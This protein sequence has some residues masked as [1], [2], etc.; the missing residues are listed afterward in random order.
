M[1]CTGVFAKNIRAF[2]ESKRFIINQGGARSSKTYSILQLLLL[3]CQRATG[4]RVVSVVSETLP[5]LKRGAI[6]DFIA[7]LEEDGLYS[8]SM[9][10]K[11]D[12]SFSIRSLCGKYTSVIEF[13]GADSHDKVRGPQRDYLFINE[14][15]NLDYESFYQLS[16]RTSKTVFIDFNPV[17]EFWVHTDL[18]PSLEEKDFSF[19]KSTY[20]D[21]EYLSEHQAADIERRAARDDNFRLV[22]ALGEIG[23]LEGLI[24]KQFKIVDELPTTDKRRIGIDFG[25]TNDPTVITDVRQFN[26]EWFVDEVTYQ[27]GLL[28]NEI[29]RIVK[30]M[31]LPA[32]VRVVC[33]SAEMKSIEDLKR[34][35]INAEPCVK[36][37]DSVVNG[38]DYMNSMPINITRRSVNG[39]KEFRN[40]K[41]KVDRSGKTTNEPIDNWN[42]FCDSFRYAGNSFKKSVPIQP[43]RY[44]W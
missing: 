41:W 44:H 39:V 32:S 20:K 5:H 16:I 43:A 29:A 9:H 24:Y 31:N 42:H 1:R 37:P 38:I 12:N 19:I 35:G 8:D 33:D 14:C 11:T 28:N 10:N 4:G 7:I 18:I 2:R 30:G 23:S 21:N 3:I 36:G 34:M 17:A 15:N 22:Y 40:Y 6:R 25:F 27:T 26:G 13:F